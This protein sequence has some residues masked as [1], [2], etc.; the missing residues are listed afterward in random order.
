M[1]N[2]IGLLDPA[3]KRIP[4]LPSLHTFISES[5]LSLNQER[6][7]QLQA[8][9]REGR[10]PSPKEV[11]LQDLVAR[12]KEEYRTGMEVPDLLNETNVRLLRSW[13]GNP[14]E[15]PLFRIVRI[16]QAMP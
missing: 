8:E 1:L 14:Q 15:L 4:D 10:P 6:L 2:L 16:A 11:Q 13:Q 3:L 5:Y 7:A 9:R 12:E